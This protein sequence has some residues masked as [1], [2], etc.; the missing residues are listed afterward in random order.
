MVKVL[1]SFGRLRM[2]KIGIPRYATNRQV[3]PAESIADGVAL[4]LRNIVC[5]KVHFFERHIKLHCIEAD[6]TDLFGS[7]F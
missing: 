6:F 1:L 5:R 7:F 2:N 3:M 4:L